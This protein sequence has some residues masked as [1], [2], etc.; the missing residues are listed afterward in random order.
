MES[1]CAVHVVTEKNRHLY[2]RQ[3]EDAYLIRH[4][5]Y[6]KERGWMA[7]DRPDGREVDQFDTNHARYLLVLESERVVGGMRMVPTTAPT[8]M[9]ELFPQLC[10][11][12]LI[13]RPDVFELSR[14]FVVPEKRGD[15]ARPRIEDLLLCAVMEYGLEEGMSQFTIVLETWWLPRLQKRGWR[16]VPLGLPEDIDGM[17]TIAVAVEVHED[18]VVQLQRQQ[19]ITGGLLVRR[20]PE[21]PKA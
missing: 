5:I 14:I 12:P 9:S 13:R 6:V 21:Q 16:V 4:A 10:L 17:S 20:L 19:G 3:I 7:L 2:E 8:L 1:S 18:S 15:H 11:R